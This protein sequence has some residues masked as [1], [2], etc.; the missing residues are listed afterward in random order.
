MQRFVVA[1]A[2]QA[3][4][5]EKIAHHVARMLENAGHLARLIDVASEDDISDVGDCD[6]A[7]IAGPMRLGTHGPALT[8]FVSEHCAMLNA[9][10]SAFLSVSL[11]AASTDP[12]DR[13]DAEARATW[14][15]A[16]IGWRPEHTKI[17]AGAVRDRAHHPIMR[18]FLHTLL[19]RKG[20]ALHPS[21]NTEFT[22]W[23]ALDR[24][25]LEFTREVAA[26]SRKKATG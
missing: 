4:Q 3:G 15:E 5:T 8:A 17:I 7:I 10:P 21:G 14:F 23:P 2:S 24:F 22:D 26:N 11:N 6:A 16:E 18:F 1:Y 12:K 9:V 25:V 13:R 20:V 19:R